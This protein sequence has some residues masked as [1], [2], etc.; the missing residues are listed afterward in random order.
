[1]SKEKLIN[2]FQL[3]KNGF[4]TG[5][6]N[7]QGTGLGLVLVKDLVEKN[8]GKIVVRSENEK[9]TTFEVILPTA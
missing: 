3:E 5:T 9:G 7:E 4:S 1:M 2:L 6:A 8:N